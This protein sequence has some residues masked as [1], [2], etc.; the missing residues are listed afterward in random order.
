MGC[1]NYNAPFIYPKKE[2]REAQLVF[3]FKLL[4]TCFV[5]LLVV[6]FRLIEYPVTF[7]NYATKVSVTFDYFVFPGI[8]AVFNMNYPVGESKKIYVLLIFLYVDDNV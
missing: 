4:I 3:L 7:F 1:D 8:C 6:Q 5:D 2:I